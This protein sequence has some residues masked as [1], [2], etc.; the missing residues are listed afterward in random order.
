MAAAD[1]PSAVALAKQVTAE[2]MSAALAEAAPAPTSP[3]TDAGAQAAR[4]KDVKVLADLHRALDKKVGTNKAPQLREDSP[5]R[6]IVGS[7]C[8]D[9]EGRGSWAIGTPSCLFQRA[10]PGEGSVCSGNSLLCP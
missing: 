6:R 10:R 8:S 1:S 2:A 3:H 5:S 7:G 4:D 9:R